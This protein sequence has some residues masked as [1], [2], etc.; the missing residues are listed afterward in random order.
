M[1]GKAWISA[2]GP[3][4]AGL[5]FTW[6]TDLRPGPFNSCRSRPLVLFKGCSE[7]S[8]LDRNHLV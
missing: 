2:K 1:A 3:F 7:I 6:A 5:V 8:R 4:F